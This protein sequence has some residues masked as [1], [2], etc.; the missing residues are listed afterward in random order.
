MRFPYGETVIVR[1][2]SK[3]GAR[4]EYGVAIR[5]PIE[6]AYPNCATWSGPST[7]RNDNQTQVIAERT[8]VLPHGTVVEATDTIVVLGKEYA[9]QGQP[10][11]D[12]S[13]FT[14][15]APGVVVE[16]RRAGG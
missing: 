1:R 8:V 6:T 4:D 3:T 16:L 15:W 2:M 11:D 7:E 13:P 9:V 10:A 5:T 14:G 12:T